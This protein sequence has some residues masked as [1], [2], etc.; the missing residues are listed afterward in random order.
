MK[1]PRPIKQKRRAMYYKPDGKP[2]TGRNP[3]LQWAKDFED[4]NEKRRIGNTVLWTG[5]WVST[6]WIGLDHS[7]GLSDKPLIY[8]T[9]A[10]APKTFGGGE[11]WQERYSTKR[12]AQLGHRRVV[13]EL[14]GLKGYW[15]ILSN[16][17]NDKTWDIRYNF[18]RGYGKAKGK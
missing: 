15:K 1:K 18:R 17:W 14:D 12:Q 16:W 11:L 10:F 4:F 3:V 8:E 9:M 13:S 2:Y 7:F 6:V 5:I